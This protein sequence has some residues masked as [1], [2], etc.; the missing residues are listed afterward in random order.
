MHRA[1]PS[2][3]SCEC[4]RS[5]CLELRGRL[6]G[7][8]PHRP[9][10]RSDLERGF[11]VDLLVQMFEHG[12][13]DGEEADRVVSLVFDWVQSLCAPCQDEAVAHAR[14]HVLARPDVAERL[15]V[16]IEVAHRVV[17]DVERLAHLSLR[18]HQGPTWPAHLTR[19]ASGA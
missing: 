19:P 2:P 12:A 16:L 8:T 9:D 18:S 1:P 11:D 3:S 17:D 6:Q 15:A 14:A 7:L 13:V 10:L 5:L 4:V